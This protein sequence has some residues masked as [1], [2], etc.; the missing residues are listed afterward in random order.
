LRKQA[1]KSLVSKRAEKIMALELFKEMRDEALQAFRKSKGA[2]KRVSTHTIKDKD[3]DVIESHT[4]TEAI[5]SSGD[6]RHQ[7]R[8]ESLQWRILT[9]WGCV[10]PP[11]GP[12]PFPSYSEVMARMKVASDR[13]DRERGNGTTGNKLP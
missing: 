8:A 5:E 1:N 4:Y 9:L 11:S 10:A 7:A 6:D 13:Y 3:G 12:E 2:R